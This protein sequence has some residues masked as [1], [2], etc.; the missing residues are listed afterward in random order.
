MAG[1]LRRAGLA[2]ALPALVGASTL[3]HWLAGRRITGLW[4]MPD[5]AIY[6]ERAL[7]LWRDGQLPVLRGEG[8]GYGL[9]YPALAGLPLSVG[10]LATGYGSLKLLQA[11]TMSLVAVP[12]FFYGRRQMRPAYA[13]IAGAL[14]VVSPLLLYSGFLMT[15]VLI[16]PLGA[17]A[18]L[19]AARAV[20]TGALTDQGIALAAAAAAI[21]TRVQS[22]VLI[23]VLVA[24]I[25]VDAVLRRDRRTLRTFWPIWLVAGAGAIVVAAAPSLF[26]AYAVTLR[27]SY[28]IGTAA[29]LVV[30]HLAYLVIS[31]AFLPVAALM[32][33]GVEL[34]RGRLT[35]PGTRALVVVSACAVVFVVLQVGVFAARFAPHIIGRDLAV[36]PPILFTVFAVWLDRGAPRRRAIVIPVALALVALVALT[37]WNRLVNIHALPDTFGMAILYHF[38]AAHASAIV[39]IAGVTA[40]VLLVC[41]PR[42]AVLLLPVL[43]LAGLAVSSVIASSDIRDRVQFDQT[44]LV[45]IPPNWVDRASAGPTAYLYDGESYWNGVWQVRFWNRSV[46]DIVALAPFRVPGPLD[47]TIIHVPPDG[48]LPINQ[49]YVVAS[50]P[51]RFDGTPIAHLAQTETDVGGLTLWRLDG[52]PRLS[53]VVHGIQANGDMTEPAHLRAYDCAGGRLELTLLPKATSILTLKLDGKVVQRATIGGLPYWNGTVFVPPASTPRSCLFEIDGQT[54]LGSTRIDFVHR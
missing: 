49:R 40:L 22:V 51:H 53:T 6:G 27:S 30:D 38:G 14:A 5:E 33:L 24:A 9:L 8:A 48:R 36:L 50:D 42:R 37:P 46:K 54:L 45:G 25:L 10:Q 41:V 16:Y 47:Q 18:L 32:I 21:L 26:G 20:E 43:M 44:N 35:D 15:E 11:L 17:L 12:I 7:A 39:A 13:L 4:I 2:L 34:A 31:T 52:A 23:P 29:G 28:P 1:T 19:A 3:L